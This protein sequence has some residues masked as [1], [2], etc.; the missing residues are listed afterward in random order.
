M[1]QLKNSEARAV[2]RFLQEAY[3]VGAV[4]ML[5]HYLVSALQPIIPADGLSY[6]QVNP[7]ARRIAWVRKPGVTLPDAEQIFGR[8][9][10]DHPAIAHRHRTHTGEALRIS[11]FLTT[12]EFHRTALYNEYYRRVN[13]EHQL[14]VALPMSSPRYIAVALSRRS[15]DFSAHE[16][17]L[18]NLLRP[19]LIQIH[20]NA[21]ATT[22]LQSQF[23]LVSQ[24]VDQAGCGLVVLEE[25]ERIETATT[26]ARRWL[27]QYFEKP[28]QSDRV[29][30]ALEQW[31]RKYRTV[32]DG[33]LPAPIE[34]FV[35][36]RE[37]KR[38]V[39]RLLS[40]GSKRIL[41][42]SQKVMTIEPTSLEPLGLSRRE[43]EVLSWI[44]EGKSSAVVGKI[45]GV[46]VR[47]IQHH[48]D[49]IYRKLG[50]ESRTAAATRALRSVQE[51]RDAS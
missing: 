22:R 25:D 45:L 34:P 2:L 47:T 50:V 26:A 20:A 40:S 5:A 31:I 28:E 42:L 48:L 8:F 7:S 29:P 6:N 19:H 37:G 16:L 10:M 21:K 49:R 44:T 27:A 3:S 51:A 33:E 18:L 41:W 36:E 15:T 24:G 35:L 38:L 39:V 43:A 13:V 9:M 32:S 23:R 46:S 4:D 30:E 14:A 1:Q 12:R 17:F 11:D